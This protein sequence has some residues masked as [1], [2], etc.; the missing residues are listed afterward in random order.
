MLSYCYVISVPSSAGR[1]AVMSRMPESDTLTTVAT[2]TCQIEP[3]SLA[4]LS[5]QYEKLDLP[6]LDCQPESRIQVDQ[7]GAE[8]ELP[9]DA[10]R[11][12]EFEL[13][14]GQIYSL[15]DEVLDI[16]EFTENVTEIETGNPF[17]GKTEHGIFV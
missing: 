2:E 12:T 16:I 13:V 3:T 10:G 4:L 6:V 14:P 7:G 1:E 17:T 11:W 15:S 8:I 5:K 9:Q